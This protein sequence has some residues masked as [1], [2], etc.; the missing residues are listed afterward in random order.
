MSETELGQGQDAVGVSHVPDE[1]FRLVV[2]R[3]VDPLFHAFDGVV[4]WIGPSI[5][6]TLGWDPVAFASTALPDL[7]HPDDVA[8]LEDLLAR[9]AA[10]NPGRGVVRLRSGEGEYLWVLLSLGAGFEADGRTHM[11]GS[12][13]E[14]NL[15]IHAEHQLEQIASHAPNVLYTAGP[16]RRATWVSSNAQRVLG[17]AAE[18]L[19]GTSMDDL[20]HEADRFTLAHR[21][22][23]L[24]SGVV[25]VEP[26]DGALVR[27]RCKDGDYRWMEATASVLESKDGE[28]GGVV[29]GLVDVDELVVARNRIREDAERLRSILDTMLDAHALLLP[30]RDPS[31]T[32]VDFRFG[33]VND[34][35]CEY[36][37]RSR[38]QL[39]G[40]LLTQLMPGNRSH[41]LVAMYASTMETG[42]PLVIEDFVYPDFEVTQS[43]RHFEV[44]AV[45]VNEALSLVW[46]DVTDHQ[47]TVAALTASEE[48]YRLLAENSSDVVLRSRDGV[49]GWVSPSLTAM[50]G[51]HPAEWTGRNYADFVY[52]DDRAKWKAERA[53]AEVGTTLVHRYR[54]RARDGMYHWI[55]AHASPYLDAADA[56]DGVVVSFRTVDDEVATHRELDRRAR[57]D[58]LTGLLNRQEILEQFS[59][60]TEAVRRTGSHTAVLFCDIDHFKTVNDTYGHL[61]GDA[62]LREVA[63]R[64]NG[65]VRSRDLV[66]RVGGDELLVVLVGVHGLADATLIAEKIRRAVETGIVVGD[67]TVSTTVSV[68]VSL[69]RSGESIGDLFFGAD[70]AMFR[71]KALGRNQVF[72]FDVDAAAEDEV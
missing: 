34:A 56:Q 59:A 14:V 51:W 24:Y 58:E 32:I 42:R 66:A 4:T 57:H 72:A 41:G 20:V 69:A 39:V 23:L 43:D 28:P 50:L 53:L 15:R 26:L 19:L 13:R 60:A 1:E 65:C 36:L 27:V 64:V 61:V 38:G 47:E 55:E 54:I 3:F 10:G 68:G 12:I 18:E 45:R 17:W 62:V 2:E 21:L 67:A 5:E 48:A 6:A 44:R 22:D 63:A 46:R 25:D 33:D 7:C 70:E 11:V 71:A 31:G 37:R 16:D 29:G 49:V 8:H 9:V 35:A 40:T 52:P 30:E